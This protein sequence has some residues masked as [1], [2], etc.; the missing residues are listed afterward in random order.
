AIASINILRDASAAAIY[1][2]R[3][4]GGV[5]LITTKRPQ[6]G[7]PTVTLTSEFF[8]ESVRR[9]PEVLSPERFLEVELGEDLGHRTDWYDEVTNKNP[10]SHRQVLNISGGSENANLYATVTHRDAKGMAIG[11]E[12][13]EFGGRLNRQFKFVDGYA[14]LSTNVSYNRVD[15]DFSNNDIFNMAIVLIPPETSYNKS[16]V[17][18]YNVLVG[19]YDYW[20]P[21]AQEKLRDDRRKYRYLLAIS[22][23][24]LILT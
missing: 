9:R 22:T 8:V 20:N 19:G 23:L 17:T 14:E 3:A 21:F 24:E 16:I 1:G 12:R 13:K 10:F 6:I 7:K 5:I 15:A 11:S 18:G 2:T 4:S